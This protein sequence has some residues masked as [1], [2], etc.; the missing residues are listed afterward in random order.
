MEPE[1][2]TPQSKTKRKRKSKKAVS[3]AD[4]PEAR[5]NVA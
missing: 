2:D 3:E 4:I 1:A 5:D